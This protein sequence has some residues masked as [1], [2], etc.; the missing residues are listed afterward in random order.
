MRYGVS[1]GE[2]L[3][4][5]PDWWERLTAFVVD[6]NHPG[7]AVALL[8]QLGRLLDADPGHHASATTVPL[9]R[10]RCFRGPLSRA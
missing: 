8:R 3:N 10:N 6:Y 5:R 9:R 2:R 7:G 4:I 1:L